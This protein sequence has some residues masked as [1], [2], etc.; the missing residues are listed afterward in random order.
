MQKKKDEYP[1]LNQISPD[2]SEFVST[3]KEYTM[4]KEE[5]DE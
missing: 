1:M 5:K 3:G 4:M 2:E